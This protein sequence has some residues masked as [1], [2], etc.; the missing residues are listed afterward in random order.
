MLKSIYLR[1]CTFTESALLIKSVTKRGAPLVT[2][3][4][5]MK[6][7]VTYEL[8]HECKQTG[9]RR[10]VI[11]TPH[12]DIRNTSVYASGNTGYG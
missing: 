8:L 12:G 11:H 7:A 3:E 6:P 4:E 5:K 9:A 10:G 2:K 1:F